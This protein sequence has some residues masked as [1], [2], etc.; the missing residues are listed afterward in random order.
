MIRLAR[1]DDDQK[2]QKF[3]ILYFIDKRRM[4]KIMITSIHIKN[5]IYDFDEVCHRK[6]SK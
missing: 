3:V 5:V 2:T 6:D 4:L 1:F